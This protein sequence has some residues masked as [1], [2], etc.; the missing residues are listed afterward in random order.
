MG[1]NQDGIGN[2]MKPLQAF[3]GKRCVLCRRV[4]APNKI[5]QAT[6]NGVSGLWVCKDCEAKGE[7]VPA[8]GGK[9]KAT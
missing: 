7:P 3:G 4:F 6:V 2:A 8:R 1:G 5:T 9:V